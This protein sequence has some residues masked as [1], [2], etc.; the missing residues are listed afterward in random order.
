VNAIKRLIERLRGIPCYRG[1][2]HEVK[3]SQPNIIDIGPF[4]KMSFFATMA[5]SDLVASRTRGNS[6]ALPFT[7]DTLSPPKKFDAQ[8]DEF[9]IRRSMGWD[10]GPIDRHEI[11]ALCE[12]LLKEL[13]DELVDSVHAADF[14]NEIE[15]TNEGNVA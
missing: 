3:P 5:G 6:M 10:N 14:W 8:W 12:R 1:R 15:A 7:F 4:E 2:H 9:A 11:D 13:N